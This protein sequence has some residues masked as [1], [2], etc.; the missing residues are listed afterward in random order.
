[1]S[2]NKFMSADDVKKFW[3]I[4]DFRHITKEQV[5]EFTSM[6]PHMSKDVAIACINQFPDFAKNSVIMIDHLTS[7]CQ[8]ALQENSKIDH[9]ILESY[10]ATLTACKIKLENDE[11]SFDQQ[12]QILDTMIYINDKMADIGMLNKQYNL[13]VIDRVLGAVLA[14]IVTGA[15]ILGFQGK[16]PINIPTKK[17]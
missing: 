10:F 5:I 7:I 8:S 6:I 12:Q 11:L 3:N 4:Q 14:V 2:N 1:M 16:L 15:G 17:D 9:V 13:K